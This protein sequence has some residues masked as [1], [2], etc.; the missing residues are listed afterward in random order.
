MEKE[1]AEL[2]QKAQEPG[3]WDDAENSQKVLQK[4]KA[5]RDKLELLNRLVNDGQDLVTLLDLGLEEKDETIFDEVQENFEQIR[6]RY[7]Q[8]R[9]QTL[10]KGDYDRNDAIFTLHAGAGG[11][12]AMDWVEMLFRMYTRWAENNQFQTRVLDFLE[13]EEAGIKSVTVEVVGENA[14]G[15]LKSEK[16]V[17]RLVRISP[18]DS[19]GRRHT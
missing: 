18:F 19:S 10:L 12:E 2:D 11:T 16:G 6:K 1:L 9:L 5:I 4:S 7:N 3:F 8:F 17:H 13:G 14:Y 15:Y